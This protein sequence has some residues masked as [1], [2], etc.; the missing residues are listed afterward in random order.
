[1]RRVGVGV[2]G[3]MSGGDADPRE[4]ARMIDRKRS[5]WCVWYG[6]KTRRFWAVTAPGAPALAC[7]EAPTVESLL[8]QLDQWEMWHPEVRR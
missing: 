5:R 7:V 3:V 4:I 2:G 6:V 8:A 1:M